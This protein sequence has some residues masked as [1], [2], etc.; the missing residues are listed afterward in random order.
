ML[1][2]HI[3][4]QGELSAVWRDPYAWVDPF[5]EAEYWAL[6]AATLQRHAEQEVAAERQHYDRMSVHL[7]GVIHAQLQTMMEW[8]SAHPPP[9]VIRG[10]PT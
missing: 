6:T 5:A 7:S 3:N 1:E 8:V 9:L 10:D 2:V 4:P